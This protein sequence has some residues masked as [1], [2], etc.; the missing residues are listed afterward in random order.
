M[1]AK[2]AT[3]AASEVTRPRCRPLRCHG[4][5]EPLDNVS[6]KERLSTSVTLTSC[7][8]RLCRLVHWGQGCGA[9]RP[10]GFKSTGP[11]NDI[12]GASV[13]EATAE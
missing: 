10:V 2:A 6:E 13:T 3:P 7:D 9:E 8:T 1:A 5:H 12:S 11:E 4:N